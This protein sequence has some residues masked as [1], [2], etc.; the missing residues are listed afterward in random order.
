MLPDSA[1]VMAAEAESAARRGRPYALPYAME[2]ARAVLGLLR[3]RGY[4]TWFEPAR[5]ETVE[6]P[7]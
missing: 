6:L 2:D 5:G 1:W 4:G 3:T 7:A